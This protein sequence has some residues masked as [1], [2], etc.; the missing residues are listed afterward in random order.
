MVGEGGDSGGAQATHGG[1][2]RRN[3][4]GGESSLCEFGRTDRRSG[5]AAEHEAEVARVGGEGD[6]VSDDDEHDVER[7]NLNGSEDAGRKTG[8]GAGGDGDE[9]DDLLIE[10][11]IEVEGGEGKDRGGQSQAQ[12]P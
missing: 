2:E 7:E 1:R 3:Q 10:A 9:G 4:T 5:E 12:S 6:G 11:V 8:D